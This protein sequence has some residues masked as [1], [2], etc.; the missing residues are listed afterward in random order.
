MKIKQVNV[1]VYQLEMTEKEIEG[2]REELVDLCGV[3]TNN[4]PYLAELYSKIAGMLP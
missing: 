3:I 1:P 4:H 2:V